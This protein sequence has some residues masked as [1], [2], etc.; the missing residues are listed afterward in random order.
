MKTL[1]ALIRD[2]NGQSM[3]EYAMIL[4]LIILAAYMA[5]TLFGG[6]LNQKYNDINN[7]ISNA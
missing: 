3:A 6:Q 7:G 1:I 2:E 5:F 4:A